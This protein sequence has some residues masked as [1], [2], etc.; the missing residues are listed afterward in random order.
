MTPVA[1][2]LIET[3]RLRAGRA[4]LW[5]YHLDRLQASC[6]ILQ[7]LAPVLEPPSGGADRALRLELGAA[8]PIWSERPVGSLEPVALITSAVVHQPYRHKT[9]DRGQFDAALA[10]ARSRSA[11]DGVLLTPDGWVAEAAIWSLFWWEGEQLC[12]PALELG[13]LPGVA[14]AR[15][16]ALHGGVAE[17]RV[18]VADLP[19]QG[20]FVANAVRGVVPVA[21]LD[22]ESGADAPA[23]AY[24]R[25]R[26]WG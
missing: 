17:R 8:G 18:R 22:G 9:T 6:R 1:P 7:L 25:T 16:A 26:F 20:L 13:V 24:L 4:P 3:I 11:D 14:R 12:T 15:L 19:R 23:T 10:E 5:P 21:S 2:V